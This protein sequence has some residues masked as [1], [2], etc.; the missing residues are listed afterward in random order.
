MNPPNTS[1][2]DRSL[3]LGVDPGYRG[4]LALYDFESKNLIE[5]MDMPI[6]SYMLTSGRTRKEVKKEELSF[7]LDMNRDLIKFAIIEEV[8]AAPGNGGVSLFNFGFSTGLLHGLIAAN[9]IQIITVKPTVWKSNLGLTSNKM[10]SCQKAQVTFPS[11]KNLFLRSKDDGR[12]E[13][14]LLA[15]YGERI[16]AN[17]KPKSLI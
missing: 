16:I 17:P 8:G 4:A 11:H 3:I 9:H 10:L 7:W 12:A 13:A 5:V 2:S 14:A 15:K 6:K 1:I